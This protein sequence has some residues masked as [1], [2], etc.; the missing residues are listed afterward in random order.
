MARY[1]VYRHPDAALRS[2]T[3]YLLDLQNNYISAVDTRVMVPL[4]PAKT[5]GRPMRDLN[6]AF[7]VDGIEVILDTA[8]LAAFPAAEL[9][10]PI[11]SLQPQSGLIAD[12]LDTLFGSY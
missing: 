1:E 3:P 9:R 5:F 10:T 11:A 12:A 6:P 4:R 7:V 8:A 2:N